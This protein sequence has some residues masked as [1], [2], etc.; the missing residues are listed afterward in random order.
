LLDLKSS[1]AKQHYDGRSGVSREN[2]EK[3]YH[4]WV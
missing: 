4:F 3:Q 1:F 2:K